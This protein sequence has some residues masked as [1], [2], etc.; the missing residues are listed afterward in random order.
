MRFLPIH[1]ILRLS[2]LVGVVGDMSFH[3]CVGGYNRWWYEAGSGSMPRNYTLTLVAPDGPGR[4][5][6]FFLM[7]THSPG[8]GSNDDL[9]TVTC[10]G[11]VLF[12]STLWRFFYQ[13]DGSIAEAPLSAEVTSLYHA[14]YQRLLIID[15]EVSASI[16]IKNTNSTD[17]TNYYVVMSGDVGR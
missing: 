6:E 1:V 7:T 16:A 9:V 11:I 8:V 3:R 4:V 2:L 10:D 5:R 14:V 15:Y 12:S 13:Y 17:P